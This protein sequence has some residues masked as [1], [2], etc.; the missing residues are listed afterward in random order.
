MLGPDVV[1]PQQARLAL[2]LHDAS[3]ARSVKRSNI[4]S[5]YLPRRPN[6]RPRVLLVY[7]LLA[8]PQLRGDLLPGPSEVPGVL[9]LERLELVHTC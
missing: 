1:V 5:R 7:S 6:H 3:R 2:R 8:D 4:S 9:H